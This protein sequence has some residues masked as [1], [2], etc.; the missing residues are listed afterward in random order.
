M[1][2]NLGKNKSQDLGLPEFPRLIFL[3]TNIVQHLYSFGEFIYDNSL[4]QEL[5]EKMSNSGPKFTR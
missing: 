3:D 2:T 4:T 5:E 1:T